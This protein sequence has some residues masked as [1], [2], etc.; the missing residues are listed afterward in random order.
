MTTKNFFIYSLILL[1]IT[2]PASAEG[3][4]LNRWATNV[5]LHENGL[6][7][8]IIQ[9]E[10]ENAGS[11]PLDGFSFQVPASK[12]TMMYDFDHTSSFTGQ[13]VEQ[14]A[15]PGGIKIIINFNRSVETGKKW[16]GR[17]GFTA[18]NWMVKSGPDYSI[19]I[20][21]EAP[22]AI[23]S[24][25]STAVS[26]SQDAE[27]RSQM[28]LPKGVEVV[29]VSPKP[30]RIL[31]QFGLM[32]P[33]WSSDNL[34]IGDIIKIK[35]SFSDVLNKIVETD[36]KIRDLS[37]RIKKEKADGMNVGEAE[38]HLKNA[39]DYN[40]NQALQSFW[41]KDNNVALEFN[42][43]ANDELKLAENSLSAPKKTM[44]PT[45]TAETKN[46]PGFEI[47]GLVLALLVSFMVKKKI[48]V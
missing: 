43:Y 28:F 26:L 48:Q 35:G 36:D 19:D 2:N 9:V 41:K 47:S 11:S 27:I 24:G 14:Q 17:I 23:V 5:T 33:T 10:I 46:T 39:E 30:F 37:A 15:V 18:E 38:A 6:V 16:N 44:T 1:I 45:E 29:S 7:E 21:I 42:G 20:P 34:H 40:T 31:F 32:V 22:Q 25:K 8:E 4:S 13:V 12:V 3:I